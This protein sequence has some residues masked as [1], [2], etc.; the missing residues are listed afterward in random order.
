M[1]IEGLSAEARRHIR[2]LQHSEGVLWLKFWTSFKPKLQ[3]A[4]LTKDFAVVA[5]EFLQFP[6][7][8]EEF[9]DL[10]LHLQDRCDE[11]YI[12]YLVVW[13]TKWLSL[14]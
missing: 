2:N 8:F 12:V 10:V 7:G 6:N 9:G 14:L 1:S 11:H 4:A 5:L 3:E 13:D